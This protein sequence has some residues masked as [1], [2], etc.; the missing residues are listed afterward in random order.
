VRQSGTIKG[1]STA[2]VPEP[3]TTGNKIIRLSPK[4]SR[5]RI[6]NIALARFKIV[7]FINPR[8]GSKLFRVTGSKR[9]GERV[10]ENFADHEA[11]E[12]RRIE[13]E[14]E[15][16]GTQ[17]ETAIRATKLTESQLRTA[18]S[19][20]N[21][22]EADHELALAV[23]LWLRDGK[24][25]RVVESPR[26]DDAVAKFKPWL[27]G[28]AENGNGI[29]TL[30]QPSRQGLRVRVDI[31][32]NSIGNLHVNDITADTVEDFLS[33]LKVSPVTRDN[34]RRAISRFFACC[35]QRPRRWSMV[36]PCREI[37]MKRARNLRQ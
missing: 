4:K 8:T 28:E 18:E 34:Y 36:N 7:P 6:A 26:I 25:R 31:F 24:Q 35:I 21:R 30:R 12:C 19:C 33:K 32:A 23:K 14:T 9:N 2:E 10:R 17:T 37:R 13:L 5:R 11:V 27:D 22:L 20:Y 29:C 15:S 3:N 16:L 1:N